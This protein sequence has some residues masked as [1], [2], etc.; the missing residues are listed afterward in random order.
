MRFA[1]LVFLGAYVVSGFSYVV[2]GFSRTQ[3]QL[4]I[5]DGVYTTEQAAR[6]EKLYADRCAKCHGEGLQGV[7]MAPALTGTT[8]YANWEG[9]TLDALFE[10]MRRSMPLD[11]PGSLSRAENADLLAHMLKVGGYPAGQ[12]P[13]DAQGGALARFKVLMYRP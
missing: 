2:S 7:E 9:E 12:S 11:A 1:C 10:R 8:F 6:G 3:Q 4:T 5:W 13:L